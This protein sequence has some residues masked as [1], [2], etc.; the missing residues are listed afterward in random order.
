M[1]TMT[2]DLLNDT[3]AIKADAQ[4][5]FEIGAVW[6]SMGKSESFDRYFH[7]KYQL[8]TTIDEWF[9]IKTEVLTYEQGAI[10]AEY[11]ER[12][13]RELFRLQHNR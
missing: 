2:R 5:L 13:A 3:K 7:E 6:D 4:N 10:Y 12:V 11:T 9:G 8:E 1:M